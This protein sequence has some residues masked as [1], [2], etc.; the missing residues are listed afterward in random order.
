[1]EALAIAGRHPQ[2]SALQMQ[3]RHSPPISA[4]TILSV[5][6][7]TWLGAHVGRAA[8]ALI[9]AATM[10]ATSSDVAE[11]AAMVRCIAYG[12]QQQ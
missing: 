11:E 10:A 5:P 1:M 3:R 12:G 9:A 6:R 7:L 4:S 2:A 8:A